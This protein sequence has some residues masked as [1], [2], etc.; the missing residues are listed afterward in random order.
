MRDFV[1]TGH[2]E[3]D[4]LGEALG[5]AEESRESVLEVGLIRII[6]L[7]DFMIGVENTVRVILT[8]EASSFPG[9]IGIGLLDIAGSI[10][11]AAVRDV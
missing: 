4:S 10:E 11:G 1:L 6:K 8:S 7:L 9:L 3:F 2:L 5:D